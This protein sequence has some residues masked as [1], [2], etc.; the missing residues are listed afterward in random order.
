MLRLAAFECVE[1]I[2]STNSELMRRARARQ[3][4]GPSALQAL[5][6]D[7]G[8]GRHG[9]SWQAEPG[10]ALLLSLACDLPADAALD[11]LSLALGAAAAAAIDDACGGALRVGL[12]WPN[13][14]LLGE[15]KLGGILVEATLL[16][17]RR[18]VVAGIGVNVAAAPPD[19]AWLA[20]ACPPKRLP[21]LARLRE[22][23]IDAWLPVL[24]DYGQHLGAMPPFA[25]WR[26]RWLARHA[27]Q[28]QPVQLLRDGDDRPVASGRLAGV[29]ARGAL[30]LAQADGSVR[31]I[32]SLQ[33]RLRRADAA[34]G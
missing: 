19:A 30:L 22:A 15:R 25:R 20:Q 6:Q 4:A 7:A 14:L 28:Q 23:L 27:W 5:V 24:D 9:R 12:K 33:W 11:G 32:D 31:A 18:W 17:A 16:D 8:R 10:A 21:S 3:L 2:D 1:R 13:D 34:T 29:D 26:T